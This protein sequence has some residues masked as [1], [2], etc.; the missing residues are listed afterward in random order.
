MTSWIAFLRGINSGQNPGQKME[1]LRQIFSGLGYRN[2]RTVIASGNVLFDTGSADRPRL[3]ADIEAALLA[4]TGIPTAAILRTKDEIGRLIAADPFGDVAMTP[5]TARQV[6]FLKETP[7]NQPAFPIRGNGYLITGMVDGAVCGVVDLT[8]TSSPD[9]MRAIGKL[10][11]G[12][13]T[14]RNWNTILKIAAR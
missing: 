6:T 13:I 12:D 10:F 1:N 14:T 9:L 2:V 5:K 4:G 8:V 3:E 7:Q 11:G